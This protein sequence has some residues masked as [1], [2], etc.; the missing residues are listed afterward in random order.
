MKISTACITGKTHLENNI[1]CQD[2]IK[3]YMSEN[4]CII[5]LSDGAGSKKYGKECAEVLCKTVINYFKEGI[6]KFDDER[7]INKLLFTLSNK[8]LDEKNSGA[9]L[10]FTVV[11]N[12]NFL[13][14]HLG[15]GVIIKGDG[16]KF[17][18][19]SLPENGHL[20]NFTY[21]L[22][23]S[24]AQNHFR[25]ATGKSSDN[26]VFI[27]ASDGISDM[28]YEPDTNQGCSACKKIAEWIEE[29]S[30]AECD[31]ILRDNL[32]EIFSNYSSDDLSIAVIKT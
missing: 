15:D 21:F 26:T 30:E 27:M 12:N 18:A 11:E 24:D 19:I 7:F 17:E 29:Y 9:T 5:V 32:K 8:D 20:V 28:L 22:P 6:G 4:L 14:G 10:L 16:N 13:I 1:D 3:K 2:V 23:A 31:E 25:Y